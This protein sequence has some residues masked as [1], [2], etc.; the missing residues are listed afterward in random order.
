MRIHVI[1]DI[2]LVASYVYLLPYVISMLLMSLAAVAYLK[3]T[4]KKNAAAVPEK[5]SERRFLFA[6]P[7]HN[8]EAS[9]A[10]T[11]RSC[12]AVLYPAA[13]F[14]VL[15]IADNCVDNTVSLAREAGARVLE[16]SDATRKSK[17]YAI[18]YLIE[19]LIRS[20][21]LDSLDA[22]V[23][24][25]ADST[26]DSK[27]LERFA[28]GLDRGSDWMQCY[29]CVGNADR[30]WR[31]RIMAYGFSL[32]NGITLA[33]QKALGLS[34]GFRG[35]GMCISRNGLRRVPWNAHGLVE[36][37]EYSWIVRLAGERIDFIE[38]A[39]VFATMLSSGGTP[40]ANQRRRWEFGRIA[41]RRRMLGPMLRSRHLSWPR[42]AAAIAELTSQPTSHI[43]LFYLLL[44]VAMC[45]AIPAMIVQKHYLLMA[46]VCISHL[47]VTLALAV[48]ALSPFIVSLIPW[49][50]ATS[51]FYFPYYII[52]RL[53]VL[54]KGDPRSWV[55]TQRESS[56]SA[57]RKAPSGDLVA[58]PPF[59]RDAG[60][61]RMRGWRA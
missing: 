55:P 29:D 16:R 20:G 11:V 33:G 15:V 53:R 42:K 38:D 26:V 27:I 58:I 31:T 51:L 30:S 17:G 56:N 24:I 46:F 43:A 21:E 28:K 3:Q 2:F 45:F 19:T 54:A 4:R 5:P 44:S 47:L 37:L 35:N 48:H 6:I 1:L 9:V 40:L 18:E 25:D 7:A 14:D 13:L 8:E 12:R 61:E 60:D 59:Q 10:E 39:A 57:T 50:F 23:F 22:L 36:D 52:W 34:A 41:V 49:R 32:Q